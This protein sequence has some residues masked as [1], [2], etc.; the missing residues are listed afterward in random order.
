MHSLAQR[1]FVLPDGRVSLRKIQA[2][3]GRFRVLEAAH[4]SP[5]LLTFSVLGRKEIGVL[6][7]ISA[8]AEVM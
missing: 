2:A 7:V 3:R 4:P 6:T 1:N 5:E 8:L